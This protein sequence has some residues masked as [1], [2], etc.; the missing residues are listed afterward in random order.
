MIPED[1]EAKVRIHIT[2]EL[3]GKSI[4]LDIYPEEWTVLQRRATHWVRNENARR[5]REDP[6]FFDDASDAFSQFYRTFRSNNYSFYSSSDNVPPRQNTSNGARE[7]TK[8][9]ARIELML[10]LGLDTWTDGDLKLV[11]RA[12]RKAHPDTGGS[13]ELWLRVM[14]HAETLGIK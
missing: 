1:K 10:L 8:E 12:Q 2:S 14:K 5:M 11:R 9:H 6:P 7:G 4:T 13:H 3:S